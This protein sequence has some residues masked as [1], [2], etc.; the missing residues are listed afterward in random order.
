MHDEA[1]EVAGDR[2]TVFLD[3]NRSVVEGGDNKRV[4]AVLHPKQGPGDGA[5]AD[6]VARP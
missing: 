5:G 3:E 4:K 1:N 6:R 2:V